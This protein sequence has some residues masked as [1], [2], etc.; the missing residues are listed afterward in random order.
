MSSNAETLAVLERFAADEQSCPAAAVAAAFVDAGEVLLATANGSPY[1][2]DPCT[3]VGC[4]FVEKGVAGTGRDHARH[5]HAEAALIVKAARIG[6]PVA[7]RDLYVTQAPCPTCALLV[8]AAGIHSVTFPARS[9]PSGWDI[10][11]DTLEDAGVV[12]REVEE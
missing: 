5:L 1:E 11:R 3:A 12:V 10:V 9:V 4:G 7:G 2:V 6:W 8:I